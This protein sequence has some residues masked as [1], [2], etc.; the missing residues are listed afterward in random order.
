M[1]MNVLVLVLLITSFPYINNE[2]I[3]PFDSKKI[4]DPAADHLPA[5]NDKRLQFFWWYYGS[6]P[7]SWTGNK[8]AQAASLGFLLPLTRQQL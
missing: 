1:I 7:I 3:L 2:F 4:E 6:N 5:V 8:K